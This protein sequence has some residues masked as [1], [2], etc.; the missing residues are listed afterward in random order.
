[1]NALDVISEKI[2]E[3]YDTNPQI[4][5]NVSLI[6]P[7]IRLKNEPVIIKGVFPHF[8]MIEDQ[9]GGAN[10]TLSLQYSDVLIGSI[11]IL[12]LE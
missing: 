10:K 7:N 8:F 5:I 1:M 11:E 3:R 6:R 4:R 9:N 12:D 2:Q